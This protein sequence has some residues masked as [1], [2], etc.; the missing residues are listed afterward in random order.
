M[1]SPKGRPTPKRRD[2]ERRTGPVAPPPKTR[3]EAAQ[4]LRAQQA[5]GRK[6]LRAGYVAG[7][8]SKL[9]PRDRGPVR[10]TVRDVVDSRRNVGV[11]LLPMALLLVAAQLVGDARVLRLATTVWTAG[12]IAVVVDGLL[13]TLRT[14]K[15]LKARHPGEGKTA[16]H[17][18]YALLRSTVLRRFRMPPP[19]VQPG[20]TL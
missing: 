6:D 20:D 7:D 19:K 10:S 11:L 17:V 12:L 1:T 5:T 8:E 4:R 3:K 16:R 15:A 2:T 18:G 14:T 9:L 13:L